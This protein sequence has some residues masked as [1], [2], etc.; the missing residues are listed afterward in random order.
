MGPDN[1]S[2]A[3]LEASSRQIPVIATIDTNS[4]FN[5]CVSYPIPSNDDS[6]L[7]CVFYFQLFVNSFLLGKSL[8]TNKLFKVY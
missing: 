3:A 1:N 4:D 2:V 8:K 6:Y 7:I 5:E